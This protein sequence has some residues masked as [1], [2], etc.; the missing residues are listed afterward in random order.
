MLRAYDV[1]AGIEK[2]FHLSK[3]L[4]AD[5]LDGAP[6]YDP[7]VSIANDTR[8]I[9]DAFGPLLPGFQALGWHVALSR[10]ALSLYR[11]FKNGQPR[12][13]PN[14]MIVREDPPVI[15]EA[16]EPKSVTLLISLAGVDTIQ[17][18]DEPTPRRWRPY[19]VSC[20][21]LPAA[22]RFTDLSHA[23]ALVLEM[24]HATSPNR[25]R[26]GGLA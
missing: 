10:D 2:H 11:L 19:V 20:V 14:V 6:S 22:R 25:S 16:S 15:D 21:S 12:K 23:T 17:E 1:A 13:A 3:I 7:R 5:A 8:T 18:M 26:S 9:Q 24:A 4:F